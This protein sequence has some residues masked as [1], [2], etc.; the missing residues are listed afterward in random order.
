[1]PR[2]AA[3]PQT[4]RPLNRPTTVK[5]IA[6]IAGVSATTVSN[7]LLGRAGNFS[8][9]T[10]KRIQDLAQELGY[11]RNS[12]ARSLV[13]RR[14][15]TLGLVIEENFNISNP[16]NL[17]F[18]AFLRVF[19]RRAV[20]LKHQVKLIHQRGFE[21]SV[22]VPQVSDG[23]IDG[24]VGLVL[25][26]ENPL[27]RWTGANGYLPAVLVGGEWKR[28]SPS[29]L[30]IDDE[31]SMGVVGNHLLELGHRRFWFVTGSAR[32][33]AL[34]ARRRGLVKSLRRQDCSLEKDGIFRTN[35]E[36]R[37]VSAI[38]KKYCGLPRSKRPTAIVCVNDLIAMSVMKE[39]EAA[40]LRIPEDFSLT[41]FDGFPQGEWSRP[42]LTTIRQPFEDLGRR[43]AEILVAGAEG[44]RSI[45]HEVFP[46][47]LLVRQ[48]TAT[49]R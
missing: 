9:A 47:E 33:P 44:A 14:S 41:G 27:N 11:R 1:M 10:A 22:I 23:S 24:M 2:K 4:S 31:H 40:G 43:A 7:V 42:T 18:V 48:S 46:G 32:H 5:D 49:P 21:E 16:E 37:D 20:D 35:M 30:D 17:Y 36:G 6:A 25:S 39:A 13:T 29:T 15:S 28:D 38:I 12:L 26:P 19:L 3:P 8:Q 45:H 34:T